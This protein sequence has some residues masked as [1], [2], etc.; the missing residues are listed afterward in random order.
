MLQFAKGY[1][2][3][4]KANPMLSL[5]LRDGL[6]QGLGRTEPASDLIFFVKGYQG[7]FE[8]LVYEIQFILH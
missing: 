3:Y 6:G 4:G 1:G 7:G 5:R 2:D 8:G